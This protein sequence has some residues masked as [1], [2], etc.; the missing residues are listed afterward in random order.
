MNPLPWLIFAIMVLLFPKLILG[1]LVA[2]AAF[3][4][5]AAI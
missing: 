1:I 2:C 5:G 3:L 4:F